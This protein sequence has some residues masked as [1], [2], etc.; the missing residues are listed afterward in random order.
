M[1]KVLLEKHHGFRESVHTHAATNR[2]QNGG[3]TQ[4]HKNTSGQGF[5]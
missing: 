1:V 5:N 3:L 4:E 2:E